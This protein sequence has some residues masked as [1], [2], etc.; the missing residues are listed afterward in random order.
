M[1]HFLESPGYDTTDIVGFGK[2]YRGMIRGTQPN[3]GELVYG[4]LENGVTMHT[5]TVKSTR[6]IS[7]SLN[8]AV[9]LT[10]TRN[11]VYLVVA[12]NRQNTAG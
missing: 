3:V 10:E 11:S 5:S 7:A 1:A 6:L 12:E 2:P 4:R 9:F 8:E